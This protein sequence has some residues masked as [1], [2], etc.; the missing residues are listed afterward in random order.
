VRSEFFI[1]VFALRILS[2]CLQELAIASGQSSASESTPN[3]GET[4]TPSPSIPW[5]VA[6]QS[7]EF[8]TGLQAAIAQALRQSSAPID[9]SASLEELGNT[10]CAP[11]SG[12]YADGLSATD[13]SIGG[14]RSWQN[15]GMLNAP[16]FCRNYS[17]I[18]G[19][20]THAVPSVN[21][22]HSNEISGKS[23]TC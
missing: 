11:I 15:T 20:E 4:S 19:A 23:R 7:P 6:F 22:A 9:Q 21:L 2:C 17:E 1:F 14:S 16:L 5:A 12:Y 8:A 18:D 10:A 13:S 3:G